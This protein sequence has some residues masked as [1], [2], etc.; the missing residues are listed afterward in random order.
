MP[1]VWTE[2]DQE[3]EVVDEGDEDEAIAEDDILDQVWV[4]PHMFAGS[5]INITV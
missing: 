1:W 5:D 4:F 3:D 2:E